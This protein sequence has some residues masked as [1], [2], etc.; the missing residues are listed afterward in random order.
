MCDIEFDGTPGFWSKT[1]PVARK[2][3]RCVVCRATIKPGQRYLRESSKWEGEVSSDACCI[4]CEADRDQFGEA[5]RGVPFANS[6]FQ[7]LID[8]I[9]DRDE[10]S[11]TRWQ[12]ML[13]GI[14][15]RRAAA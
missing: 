15:A 13:E 6:F 9:D 8:C 5:H 14:K 1:H 11:R 4:T 7:F 12:P 3:H 2:E 10:E